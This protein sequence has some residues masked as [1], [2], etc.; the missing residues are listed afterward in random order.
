MLQSIALCCTLIKMSG[1]K[2]WSLEANYKPG[3]LALDEMPPRVWDRDGTDA[4]TSGA[5]RKNLK[6]NYNN[7]KLINN[8]KTVLAAS[9][10]R[11]YSSVLR[12]EYE[13]VS[14]ATL[15]YW[16]GTGACGSGSSSSLMGECPKGW[17]ENESKK[18]ELL[19]P[20]LMPVTPIPRESGAMKE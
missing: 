11:I 14:S 18:D 16:P 9:I 19:M 13:R 17:W 8:L 20:R 2:V 5:E 4:G 12:P 1:S 15:I 7:F 10:S 6:K 3:L